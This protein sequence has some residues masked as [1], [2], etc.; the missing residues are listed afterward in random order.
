MG[1]EVRD[2]SIVAV[3]ANVAVAGI[4]VGAS[5]E[6]VG[7]T[8][9][10]VIGTA[11]LVDVSVA[12]GDGWV[13]AATVGVVEA[14]MGVGERVVGEAGTGA[15][16]VGVIEGGIGVAGGGVGLVI[17]FGVKVGLTELNWIA[18]ISRNNLRGLPKKSLVIPRSMA[19]PPAS[20]ELTGK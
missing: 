3:A 17:A 10:G 13:G 4:F 14:G 11:V 1:E 6:G 19:P 7:D 9:V 20:E 8:E 12:D 18:P 5:A 2:G 15:V 16:A